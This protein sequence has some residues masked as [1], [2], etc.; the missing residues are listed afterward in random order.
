VILN[1]LGAGSLVAMLAG[2][3]GADIILMIGIQS[4][5]MLLMLFL[6]FLKTRFKTA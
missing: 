5:G 2:F 1:A 4:L 3:I 6:A